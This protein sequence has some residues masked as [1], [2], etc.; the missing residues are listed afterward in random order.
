M[1]ESAQDIARL[2]KELDIQ[3]DGAKQLGQAYDTEQIK[4][5]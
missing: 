3:A 4:K 1:K 5:R 2:R